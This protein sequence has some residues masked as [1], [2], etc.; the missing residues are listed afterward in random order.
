MNIGWPEG[1]LLGIIVLGLVLT[2]TVDGEKKTGKHSLSLRM[3]D[4][5]ITIGLLYWGGFFA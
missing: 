1:I 2:A 3:L 4:A 5:M